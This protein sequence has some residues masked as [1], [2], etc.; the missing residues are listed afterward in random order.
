MKIVKLIK[1]IWRKIETG[2]GHLWMQ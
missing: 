2:G 1:S